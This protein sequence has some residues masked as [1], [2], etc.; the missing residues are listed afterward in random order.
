MNKKCIS[1]IIA[2]VLLITI[3]LTAASLLRVWY[4]SE[5]QESQERTSGL[6]DKKIQE[7]EEEID[8]E[9]YDTNGTLYLRN[10]GLTTISTDSIMIYEEG[11]PLSGYTF[12][13]SILYSGDVLAIWNLTLT[14]GKTYR[15]TTEVGYTAIFEYNIGNVF[16]YPDEDT[17]FNNGDSTTITAITTD[18][19]GNR[20]GGVGIQFQTT[21]GIFS[22][23]G[24]ST[25]T[26]STDPSGE[27]N[28]TLVSDASTGRA[29]IS[30]LAGNYTS[31]TSVKIEYWWDILWTKRKKITIEENSGNDLTDYQV[32]LSI[33]HD[34]DMQPN[35]EDLRFIDSDHNELSYWI[36]D[37]TADPTTVWVKILSIP[38]S[39]TGTVYMYYGNALAASTSDPDATFVFFDSFEN[40]TVG[41]EPSKWTFGGCTSYFGGSG[42][43]NSNAQR[44]QVVSNPGNADETSTPYGNNF[45]ALGSNDATGLGGDYTGE[46]ESQTF[47]LPKNAKIEYWI[48][49]YDNSLDT[50]GDGMYVEV[51]DSS[52]VQITGDR[53]DGGYFGGGNGNTSMDDSFTISS[54]SSYPNAYIQFG[55]WGNDGPVDAGKMQIDFVRVRS[56]VFP[57]P[58]YTIGNEES[59]S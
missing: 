9:S 5:Q 31:M 20:L 54:A 57:E 44:H 25:Y 34:A 41:N 8:A 32:R 38:E 19:F 3:T 58:S 4:F 11:A 46:Y 16:L 53:W 49:F 40:D 50:G 37:D 33:S 52:D 45:L 35:Y 26:T 43:G 2:V 10:T 13:S 7:T 29:K 47:D 55:M 24:T 51:M 17:I 23:S 28:A 15:I 6:I 22:E 30:A 56:Y 48:A 36:E 1:P 42:N 59:F 14:I 18:N 12:S 39:S 21:M 27:A